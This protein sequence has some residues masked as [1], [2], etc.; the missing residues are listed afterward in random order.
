MEDDT[1]SRIGGAPILPSPLLRSAHLDTATGAGD[2]ATTL[3]TGCIHSAG[4][5]NRLG[6]NSTRAKNTRWQCELSVL[7]VLQTRTDAEA[8][9]DEDP[10]H[11]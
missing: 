4:Q 3:T 2:A 8:A 10:G 11:Y 9:W 5:Y 6:F 1:W 7:G